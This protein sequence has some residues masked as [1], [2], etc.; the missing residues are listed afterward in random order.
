MTDQDRKQIEAA[1]AAWAAMKKGPGEEY[2]HDIDE[3]YCRKIDT[4]RNSASALVRRVIELE[5][6]LKICREAL[7]AVESLIEESEGVYELHHLDGSLAPWEVLRTGAYFEEWLLPFDRA[8]AA[9]KEAG[10]NNG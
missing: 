8:L 2:P 3:W 10:V 1:K 7:E 4:L 5:D 9:L 6:L